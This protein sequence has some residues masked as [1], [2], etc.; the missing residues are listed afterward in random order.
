MSFIIKLKLL[1]TL[2]LFCFS[3]SADDSPNYNE[4]IEG[5]LNKKNNTSAPKLIQ[6]NLLFNALVN[7][8]FPHWYGTPWDFNG[9][10]NIPNKGEIACGYFVSTTLKHIGFNLNRYR[11]AQQAASVIIKVI[12]GKDYYQFPNKSKA[13]SYFKKYPNSIFIVG[14]DY[15]LGFVANIEDEIYFIHSDYFNGKVVKELA[16]SST[17]FN[18][19]KGY[20][21][22]KLSRN[23]LLIN[24]WISNEKIY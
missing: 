6:E 5:I 15:H 17:G 10:S 16:D 3:F 2:S 1:F 23:E 8:V 9:I 19:T 24:K 21:V 22:G 14:L 20:F 11:T 12:C 18:Y 7:Q 4:V 13:L